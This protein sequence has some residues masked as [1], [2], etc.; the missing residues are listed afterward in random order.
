MAALAAV[1]ATVTGTVF[2][3]ALLRR[4]ARRGRTRASLWWGLSLVQF[5]VASAA[6]LLGEVLGWSAP[7]FRVFYL[8]GAV[9]NVLWL[10]LGTVAI[11]ARRRGV[12]TTVG[13]LLLVTAALCAWGASAGD[14]ALWTPSVVVAGALGAACLLP[15][16]RLVDRVS[17]A[18]V[19]CFTAVATVAVLGGEVVAAVPVDALPEGRELFGLG[20][21]G[22]AVA[23]NAV[24]SVVVVVGALASSA[25]VVWRRPDR[26]ADALLSGVTLTDRSWFA[27]TAEWLFAGRRGAPL[28]GNVVRGN[29]LI[30]G[31]V[32]LAAASALFAYLSEVAGAL[33]GVRLEDTETTGHA[34]GLA[35]GVVV[36]YAGFR[37]TLRPVE[38]QPATADAGRSRGTSH[39][40]GSA[41][42]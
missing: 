22:L 23:G 31:G 5:A 13:A 20:V 4:W 3:V 2:A 27:A 12:T 11:N 19:V 35:V 9:T 36:M 21:R 41:A 33:V 8:F 25:H 17:A 1:V 28:A 42:P 7:V 30:A 15:T 6:L 26:E 24:G 29:L 18:V 37:R 39:G 32:G 34:V 14:A 40:H 16:A 38:Q 10:G